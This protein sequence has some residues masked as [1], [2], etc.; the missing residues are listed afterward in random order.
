MPSGDSM[1]GT[2]SWAL[3][4]LVILH[5]SVS[6]SAHSVSGC[7]SKAWQMLTP[8]RNLM[9][10]VPLLL[11]HLTDEET[12]AQKLAH[13]PEPA[14][15]GDRIWIRAAGSRVHS[16]NHPALLISYR[17]SQPP[18]VKSP[19]SMFWELPSSCSMLPEHFAG[20]SRIPWS[21]DRV[22]SSLGALPAGSFIRTGIW[23]VSF[24]IH[25]ILT[26]RSFPAVF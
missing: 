23:C 4:Y 26:S 2:L 5:F 21:L 9:M 24:R 19:W 3:L 15:A 18:P 17:C 7:C 13:D 8:H 6:Q 16:L 14:S 20:P 1:P 10:L 11:S 25:G 12:E 22:F